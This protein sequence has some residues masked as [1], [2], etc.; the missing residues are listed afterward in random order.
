MCRRSERVGRML[1]FMHD[2]GFIE[3]LIPDFSL[4]RCHAQ[5][6]AYHIYTTDEHTLS[7]VR[8]LAYLKSNK[9]ESLRS[10]VDAVSQVYDMDLLTLVCIFHDIGKGV[11]GN[12][13][14]TG[15]S[16][17]EKY[18]MKMDFSKEQAEEAALLVYHHLAMNEVAQRRNL[19]DPQTIQDFV[20]K[21][22]TPETLRKL[23]V[24]TYCDTSSVHPDAWSSW[25]A[26]LLQTLYHK[27]LDFMASSK[28]K[29]ETFEDEKQKLLQDLSEE[30]REEEIVNHITMMPRIYLSSTSSKEISSHLNMIREISNSYN[31]KIAV[32]VSKYTTH[33][34]IDVVSADRPNLLMAITAALVHTN[35][36]LSAAH[37]H[38]RV[39]GLALDS[40]HLM[41]D[42]SYQLSLKDLKTTLEI[43]IEENLFMESSELHENVE[44]R[45]NQKHIFSGKNNLRTTHIPYDIRFSND[46]SETMSTFEVS[47]P[48][49]E[50][51]MYLVSRIFSD[52]DIQIHGATL[53]TEAGVA[54]DAF[55][56]T[57]SG[58]KK[59]EDSKKIE[60]I[61]KKLR[62][63]LINSVTS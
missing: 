28:L 58:N 37:I 46:T 47:C 49:Q 19:E 41:E 13:R 36:S 11:L 62:E 51:L 55:Y 12:H 45:L 21:V 35:L 3:L 6:N 4:V 17:V 63:E 29:Q 32:E 43:K 42:S 33:V 1:R 60:L 2:V 16:M 53:A 48:D 57:T 23:Y 9:E 54:I 20:D 10:L 30:F 27:A 38:T 26:S 31:K 25:K 40:F 39:D 5:H 34:Q 61:Q 50:G 8:Q 22:K 14:V 44:S 56:V 59:L 52:M 18:M 7:V 15:A 24:L